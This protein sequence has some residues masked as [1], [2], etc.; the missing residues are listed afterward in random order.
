MPT[1]PVDAAL[2]AIAAH[3]GALSGIASA[4]R[5]WPEHQA[6]LDLTA[7][8]I[9]TLTT[10]GTEEDHCPPTSVDSSLASP[11][12]TETYRTGYLTIDVQLDLWCAYRAQRDETA[13]IVESG[14]HNDIPWRHGLFLA[15]TDY[16]SRPITAVLSAGR[17]EEE[18]Q[19]A[20]VGE[21][22][23]RWLLTV[24][25]DR[26]VQKTLPAQITGTVQTTTTADGVDVLTTKTV[27]T[28]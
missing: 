9:V 4:Q 28:P 11:N 3:F 7:G 12:T 25:T 13:P 16:Y 14:A 8:P 17:P 6:D 22:R 21:W 19:A 15:S 10:I 27:P 26:V 2:D 20:E 5:G 24:Q 18:A 1:D 23:F